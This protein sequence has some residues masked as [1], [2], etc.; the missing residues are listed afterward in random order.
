MYHKTN[1]ALDQRNF[2]KLLT[3]CKQL[4]GLYDAIWIGGFKSEVQQRYDES[5]AVS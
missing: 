3:N 4:F 1:L 2:Q 5:V